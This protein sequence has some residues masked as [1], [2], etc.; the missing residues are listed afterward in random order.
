MKWG[1]IPLAFPLTLP[2]DFSVGKACE[3]GFGRDSMERGAEVDSRL[4]RLKD[5]TTTRFALSWGLYWNCG[6]ALTKNI[7]FLNRPSCA[8]V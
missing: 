4:N 3:D 5:T 1:V 7:L 6:A 8:I 2:R